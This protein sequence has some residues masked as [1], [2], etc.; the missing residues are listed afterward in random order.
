MKFSHAAYFATSRPISRDD[1]HHLRHIGLLPR[2][3]HDAVMQL[4][5]IVRFAVHTQFRCVSYGCR[6]HRA[7]TTHYGVKILKFN[8]TRC[9]LGLRFVLRAQRADFAPLNLNAYA[10]LLYL[11]LR[12]GLRSLAQTNC[13]ILKR[14]PR[15]K[16]D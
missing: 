8:A 7:E 13:K 14:T 3:M 10:R 16:P 12:F 9:N 11:N 4:N 1:L 6:K 2:Q 15:D 5:L